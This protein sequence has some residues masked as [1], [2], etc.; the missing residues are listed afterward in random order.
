M[1]HADPR[2]PVIKPNPT[3]DDCVKS[4]RIM[5][6]VLVVNVTGASWA[7]GY[8]KGHP[9]R[10]LVASTASVIGFTFATFMVLQD[11]SARFMG[12]KENAREVKIYGIAPPEWQPLKIQQ[13][14]RFPKAVGMSTIPR[15]AIDWQ[16]YD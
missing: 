6:Y 8:L 7:Y 9:A 13:D 1:P 10:R 3:V 16:D 12:A 14:R 2:W 4:M 5:D 11:T 15:P